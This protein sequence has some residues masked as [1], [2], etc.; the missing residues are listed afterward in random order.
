MYS[1]CTLRRAENHDIIQRFLME[2]PDFKGEKII[3]PNG[4]NR[5]V[6]EDDH[7][8]TLIPGVYGTDGFFVAKLRRSG[9]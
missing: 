2:H 8:L 9:S 4:M 6:D 7:C 5:M 3:L 1:T